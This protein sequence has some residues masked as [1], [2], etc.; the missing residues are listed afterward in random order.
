MSIKSNSYIGFHAG[1]F[2][3]RI[4]MD[5]KF[6]GELKVNNFDINKKLAVN[7]DAYAILELLDSGKSVGECS[8]ELAGRFNAK[9]EEMEKVVVQVIQTF[10]DNGVADVFPSTPPHLNQIPEAL[11]FP[12]DYYIDA[13]STEL[14]ST[15]NLKCL[16]CYG[17]FDPSRKEVISKETAFDILDQLRDLHCSDISFTGGEVLM[18]PDFLDI[19]R[20]TRKYNFKTSFLTNGTLIT[21]ELVQELKRIGYFE[22]Q[23]SLDADNPEVHDAFRGVPGAFDKAFAG[24]KMLREADFPVAIGFILNQTNKQC[25]DPIHKIVRELGINLRVGPLLK[26]GNCAVNADSLYVD[27]QSFYDI[28]Y[29]VHQRNPD[30]ETEQANREL[31]ADGSLA[32]KADYIPRCAAGK[33]KIAVKANGDVIPC[34][35][36]PV[37][38]TFY[39]G[40]I[41]KNSIREISVAYDCEGKIGDLNALSLEPCNECAHV[42]TCKAG[43]FA[44]SYAEYGKIDILDPFTCIRNRV[45]NN[46]P[47]P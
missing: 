3:K 38:D 46:E 29:D 27:H 44:A 24:I 43:C 1:A 17:S 21:P 9:K 22:I 12:Y 26:Y 41:Y 33:G 16:H 45:I 4:K 19:L 34:E 18:H 31:E 8:G 20:Y 40:N 25:L 39:M 10:V 11:D 7:P 13:F 6:L 37:N 5:G 35:I 23:V 30:A 14:L 36:L 28:M 42:N 32:R 47:W 15:C 2:F